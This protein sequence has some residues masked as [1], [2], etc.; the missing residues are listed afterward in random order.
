MEKVRVSYYLPKDL[1]DKLNEITRKELPNKSK[2]IEQLLE[3]WLEERRKKV[4]KK[5]S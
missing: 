4:D 3:K 1:A 5:L 2:L